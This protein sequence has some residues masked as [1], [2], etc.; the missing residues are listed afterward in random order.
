MVCYQFSNTQLF[1]IV[2]VIVFFNFF[3]AERVCGPMINAYMHEVTVVQR[4][5]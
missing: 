2:N 4:I 5:L 3:L 1:V